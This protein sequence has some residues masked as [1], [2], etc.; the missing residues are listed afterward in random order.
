M[1]PNGP[2]PALEKENARSVSL[3]MPF[4]AAVDA[5]DAVERSVRFA[6][7]KNVGPPND[8]IKYDVKRTKCPL[9]RSLPLRPLHLSNK[10]L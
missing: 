8:V 4:V 3:E 10:E 9:F 2:T 7:R 1:Y 5:Y 6:A